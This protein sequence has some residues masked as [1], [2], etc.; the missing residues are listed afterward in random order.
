MERR[1]VGGIGICYRLARAGSSKTC[2]GA[3]A[4]SEVRQAIVVAK[5]D[6]L[7]RDVAFVSGLMAQRVPFLV[8][9]LG[10]DVD[11]FVLHLFAALADAFAANAL[12]LVRQIQASGVASTRVIAAALNARG[13]RTARGQRAI[14]V[15]AAAIRGMDLRI[16]NPG[17][18][19]TISEVG[20]PS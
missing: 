16:P 8:A 3:E 20:R 18:F 15:A 4:C 1:R 7:P 14:A 2:G 5:L 9:E 13:I 11:P 19:L 6:R 17:R 10:A 12:P